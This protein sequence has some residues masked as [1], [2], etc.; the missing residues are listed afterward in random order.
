MKAG[1]FLMLL[2]ACT[3]GGILPHAEAQ[4]ER[5]AYCGSVYPYF[6]AA[7]DDKVFCTAYEN[8]GDLFRSQNTLYCISLND[9]TVDRV[10]SV[11]N[12]YSKVFEN[13]GMVFFTYPDSWISNHL[14]Y[15]NHVWYSSGISDAE[16]KKNWNKL[17]ENNTKVEYRTIY[18][19]TF[20]GVYRYIHSGQEYGHCEL[21]KFEGGQYANLLNLDN[22]KLAYGHSFVIIQTQDQQ[23]TQSLKI[24]DILGKRTL[25]VPYT[26][27]W[28][29]EI[30][31]SGDRLYYTTK[32]KVLCYDIVSG[33]IREVYTSNTDE[34]MALCCD[35]DYLYIIEKGIDRKINL[36]VLTVSDG[37][38]VE[39]VIIPYEFSGHGDYLIVDGILLCGS[40]STSEVIAYDFDSE[41]GYHISIE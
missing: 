12:A 23:K 26:E 9:M 36:R 29:P 15:G 14:T 25:E 16:R 31:V 6:Q 4:S 38:H 35:G 5:I 17:C 8:Y 3:M 21:H 11:R 19:D 33:S 7:K 40:T 39:N 1:V 32:H 13:G 34:Y 27:G 22:A 10:F 37:T 41:T 30:I 24:Y 20:D 2:L 28:L 18:F